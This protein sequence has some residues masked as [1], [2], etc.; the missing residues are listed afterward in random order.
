MNIISPFLDFSAILKIRCENRKEKEKH[1]LKDISN[2]KNRHNI[3]RIGFPITIG[4]EEE[5]K[6]KQAMYSDTLLKYVK[7]NLIDIDNYQL[8]KTEVQKNPEVI[9][10]F[11][12][13]PYGEMKIKINFDKNLSI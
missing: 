5:I 8:N 2:L 12:S 1:F 13:N 6:G 10:D 3:T 4:D 7:E 11:R 9:V